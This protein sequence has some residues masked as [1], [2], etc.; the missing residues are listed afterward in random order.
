M[1]QERCATG[2]S[3]DGITKTAYMGSRTAY[4]GVAL[5]DVGEEKMRWRETQ[6]LKKEKLG[7]DPNVMSVCKMSKTGRIYPEI[8]DLAAKNFGPFYSGVYGH[9]K[10]L[11]KLLSKCHSEVWPLCT[12]RSL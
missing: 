10:N 3:P 8:S 5:T 1:N 9:D 7:C 4:M 2:D 6:Y 11:P 12:V